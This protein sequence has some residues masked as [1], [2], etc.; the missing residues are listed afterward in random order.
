MVISVKTTTEEVLMPAAHGYA[1]G[2]DEQGA[3]R[4]MTSSTLSTD[5]TSTPRA[6]VWA[7]HPAT[8]QAYCMRVSEYDQ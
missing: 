5:L 3:A 6:W 8:T 7:L 2:S 1:D 4:L